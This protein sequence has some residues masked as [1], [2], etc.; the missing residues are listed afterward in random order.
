MDGADLTLE[1]LREI[2]DEIRT[3]RVELKAEIGATNSRLDVVDHSLNLRL[4][5]V[6]HTLKDLAEQLRFIPKYLKALTGCHADEIED[7]SERVGK[8]ET[9]VDGLTER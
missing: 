3:T 1:V 5:V 9:R 6:D 2:R 4:D 7:L 8:L